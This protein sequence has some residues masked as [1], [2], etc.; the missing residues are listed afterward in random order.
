M[1]ELVRPGRASWEAAGVCK[2]PGAAGN[3]APRDLKEAWEEWGATG[4]AG[5][6]PSWGGEA[7]RLRLQE[8]NLNALSEKSPEEARL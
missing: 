6:A 2:G 4:D 1:Q 5:L 7:P 3:L 8:P